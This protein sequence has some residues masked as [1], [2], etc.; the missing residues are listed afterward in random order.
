MPNNASHKKRLRQSRVRNLRN[1]RLRS[2]IRTRSRSLMAMDSAE[3]ARAA[4]S[5]LYTILDRAARKNVIPPNAAA[6]QKAKAARHVNR[7]AGA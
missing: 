7:L 6:R 3:D 1:R 4:L 2:E 5:E